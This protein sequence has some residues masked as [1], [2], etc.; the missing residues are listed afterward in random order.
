M[1]FGGAPTP[2]TAGQGDTL[3]TLPLPV[4]NV[5]ARQVNDPSVVALHYKVEH[6]SS[7]DYSRTEPLVVRDDAF[8][9][10][11]EDRHVRFSMKDHFAT[12]RDARDTVDDYIRA[13]EL[14]AALVMGPSAF[15][16]RFDRSE[17]E[18]R[19]PTPGTICLQGRP[20]RAT[21]TLGKARVTVSPPAYPKPPS[22]GLK[23]SPD[24]ESM[25]TRYLAYREGKEPLTT[26]AY[27]CLTVLEASTGRRRGRRAAAAK[28]YYISQPVLNH[29]GEFS[30]NR[31]GPGARKA[32]SVHH[33]LTEQERQFLETAVKTIIRRA[34]Q[35]AF[36]PDARLTQITRHD[37]PRI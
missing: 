15:T 18:D 11:V 20:L 9:V 12:E 28:Q 2:F 13:W 36:D 30:S 32:D 8:D 35:I 37:L 25:F 24:V 21:A 16:L 10:R 29:L 14:D 31:G 5:V 7:I 3:D 6:A 19:N 4:P 34:A 1:T 33:D 23:R 17:I 22:E 27:F 26:M